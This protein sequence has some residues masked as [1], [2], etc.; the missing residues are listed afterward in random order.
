M[1]P[2]S[3]R[4]AS[5]RLLR[6]AR[7]MAGV[8][9]VSLVIGGAPGVAAPANPF[10]RVVDPAAAAA[11]AVQAQASQAAVSSAAVAQAQASFAQAAALRS[12]MDAA[13][14]AA[15][16]AAAAAQSAVPNGLAAGGLQVA[17]GAAPGTA[18]WQGANA[19]TQSAE[20]NGRTE[21]DVQQTQQQAILNWKSFNVGQQTDLNFDQQGANW[22][23]LNR[24]TDPS[25]NPSQ[26]LGTIKA[27]GTVLIMN[28]NG[29]IFGGASQVNVGALVAGAAEITD[30]QFL[31]NGLYSAQSNGAY[32]PSFSD[33]AGAVVV[34]TGAQIATNAPASVT[35]GGGYVLLMGQQVENQGQ[36]VTPDGQAELAAG[37]AFLIRPGLGTQ[38][39]TTSTTRGNEIAPRIASPGSSTTGGA[40]LVVNTGLIEADTGDVTLAGESV[41]NQGLLLST[42]SVNV[43]GTIHLLSP[44]ND[45]YSSVT[46]APASLA[47]ILPDQSGATAL[48]SQRAAVIAASGADQYDPTYFNDLSQLADLQDE[49]RVEIV[50]GGNVEFQGGSL[51]LANGGQIA[52][53][54]VGRIQ[55]DDGA[56]IDVSGLQDVSL[57][58]AD[59]IIEVNIQGN[60][61]RD[62]PNNRDSG[63]LA[64]DNVYVNAEDLTLV[65][66]GTGGYASDR[67]YTAGGL[68]EV[69]G[70]MGTTGHTIQEWEAVGG[71]ITLSANEVVAQS[72][73]TFN[74]SGG[75]L[76]YQAG[77][78]PQSY[79]IA[80]T[81][82]IYNV[83]NAPADLTYLGVYNGF[84]QDHAHW[85]VSQS[86]G[87]DLVAPSEIYEQ[88]YTVGRDAGSL[89]LSTPTSVF[90]G[91]IVAGVTTGYGQTS[92]RP[93]GV[94]DPYTLPQDV[95]PL[96]GTL[97]IGQ[98]GAYGLAG[99]YDTDVV[100]GD[101]A[102]IASGVGVGT[103]LPS[104]RTGTAWFDAAQINA[105]G[106]GGLNIVTG[107]DVTVAAPL[108]LAP[109]AQVSLV[110]PD[111]SV[112][113]DIV[114]PSGQV[115]L[116]NLMHVQLAQNQ[117][118][119]WSAL[120]DAGG[121]ASVAIQDGATVDLA[122]LWVNA[123]QTPADAAKL[124]FI[125]GGDL[126]VSTT[127]SVTL[128]AGGAID[129]SSGGAILQS[130]ATQGGTGGSV[131]L[132]A[133]DYSRLPE[134]TFWAAEYAGQIS[135]PLIVDGTIRG[136]GFNGGGTL[137]LAAGQ[138]VVIGQD[139]SLSG[140]T[141][142]AG[143]AAG[144][145]VT[146]AQPVT[147]PA[148][149]VMP[150]NY[151][152][153]QN[154]VPLDTP[155]AVALTPASQPLTT[156]AV[157]K[158]PV[159]MTVTSAT[160]A[161]FAG[162]TV[163]AGTQIVS[164]SAIPAGAT[165]PSAVFPQGI[166]LAAPYLMASYTA[167]Q[168][169][170]APVTLPAGFNAPAG[171]VFAQAVAIQPAL[172]LSPALFQS[173]FSHYDISST[174]GVEVAAGTT[175]APTVPVYRFTDASFAAPTGTDPA[176]AGT[177]WTPPVYTE[178]PLADR[179]T[180]RV[181]ASLALNSLHDLTMG[182]GASITVDPGQ[183]VGL[184]A[185]GQTT[186]LG[187]VVAHGGDITVASL[188]G[189]D[190]RYNGGYGDFSLTRS[191]WVGDG[192]VL[193]VS[194]QAYTAVDTWGRI[195]GEAQD[196]GTILLGGTGG[197]GGANPPVASDAF[198]IIRPG[199]VL[200]ASG[201]S[202]TLDLLSP[203]QSS[204][205]PV[206]DATDGGTIGLY[207][208]S[209]IYLDGMVRAAAGGAGAAGGTLDFVEVGH[210]YDEIAPGAANPYAVGVQAYALASAPGGV[211]G[212]V[213]DAAQTL[214]NVTIVQD[215]SGDALG[216]DLAPGQADPG[217]QFGSAVLGVNQIAAGGFDSVT[218]QTRD[219]FVF[220]GDVDLAVG[221]SLTLVGGMITADASTP[222]IA[223]N[224]SAPHVH[225]TGW[226]S[227]NT[228]VSNY[229]SGLNN[230]HGVG[231]QADA[232]SSFTVSAD[233]IDLD[234]AIQFG[235]DAQQGDGVL[236]SLTEIVNVGY[237]SAPQITI[238]APGFHQVTFDSA[239]DVRFGTGSILADN[240]TVQAAQAYP[241]SGA[242][243][244]IS[245]GLY[246]P[247]GAFTQTF[248]P[249][250]TLTFLTNGDA[251]P[252]VPASVF[253]QLSLVA[254]NI[255]QD[256][257]LRAPLGLIVFNEGLS[258]F[259]YLGSNSGFKSAS[260]TF[261]AN[262]VTSVSA[263]GLTMPF[264]GTSDGVTYDGLGTLQPLGAT[265]QT[266]VLLPASGIVVAA[267]S[268][269]ADKGSVL[270][271]SGGGDLTGA[272]F[273]SGRGGSVD[274]LVNPL[275][276][277]DP[278]YAAYSS[279]GDKVYAIVPGYASDYA[280]V[281][282]T[283]GAGDPGIGEQITIGSGVPGLPAGTYTLLPSSY[284]LLPGGFRVE[285]GGSTTTTGAVAAL[286]NG[287]IVTSAALGV[288]NTGVHEALPVQVVLSSGAA[289]RTYSQYDETSYADFAA[290]QATLFGGVRPTLPEDGK[291]LQ[292]SLGLDPTTQSDTFSFEGTALMGGDGDGS[293]AGAL[294]IQG[295]YGSAIDIT[296]ADATP[297]A[298]HVTISSDAIN[299]FDA[300]TVMIGGGTQY[301][302][303]T[304]YGT[305]ERLLF[306][307]QSNTIN[308]LAGADIR[309]GQVFLDGSTI[310]V[311][312]GA[313]IDT[314]GLG[315]GG[316]DSSY[317][318]VYANAENPGATTGPAVLVVANGFFNFLPAVGSGAINIASGA[319]LLTDGSIVIAAPGAANIGD[320][321]LAARY[322][323]VTQQEINI[324]TADSLAAASTAGDLPQGWN[325]T[326]DILDRLLAPPAESG[327]PAL[328]DLTLTAG[329][330]INFIGSV[331]LDASGPDG[332]PVQLVL[333]T[334]AIY[335]LGGAGDV[336][337]ITTDSLVWN[338]V[339][340]GNG[341]QGSPSVPY[342][343]RAPAAITPGGPGTG[344]G[345]L[346]IDAKDITFG[347]D[348]NGRPTDGTTLNRLAVGFSSV[349]LDASDR[350]TASDDGTLTVGQSLNGSGAPVGGALNLTTPL[351]TVQNGAAMS[352]TA[353][354]A[355][356]IAAPAGA[357]AADTAAV[358]NI[359]G[360]LTF[361]GA[362]ISLD[363]AVA[364]PSGQLTLDAAGDV[365]LGDGADIDLS[366]RGLVFND[367]TEYSWGGNLVLS[368][369][370][371]SISQAGGSV[372]DVSAANNDAGSLSA[373]AAN[374]QVTLSGE[375]SGAGGDKYAGG[376][377]S[378][379]A[380]GVGDFDALNAKLNAAG[381]DGALDFDIRS[382]DL[383][384]DQTVKASNVSISVDG[385][386][387]TVT[388][389]IDASGAAPGS[390]RLMA[391]DDLTVAGSAVLDA[392]GDVL[393]ADSYGAPID[394]ENRA[395]V[396]L[397]AGAG[398]LTLQSGATIDVSSPDPNPQGQVI[399]DAPRLGG[400]GASATAGQ[401][402][403]DP[404][405][406]SLTTGADAP[407]N[408]QGDDVAVSAGGP[409]NIK[410]AAD[411]TVNAFATYANAPADPNDANGQV[412]DQAY[413]DLIDQDSQ[414]FISNAYG[415]DVAGGALTA[416]LQGKLAG[417][418]AYGSAFHLRPGVEIDS[419]APGGDLTVVGDLQLAGYRYG[420]NA[421]RD[422]SS[423][424]FGA[425]EPMA[426]V[427]RAGGDLTVTGSISDGFYPTKLE[428][429]PGTPGSYSGVIDNVTTSSY[430][431]Y[432]SSAGGG[433][434][435]GD[436]SAGYADFTTN[437]YLAAD[438][439][440]PD[441]SFYE[442][443]GGLQGADGTY[444]SPGQTIPAGTEL[445]AGYG[446][447]FEDGVTPPP[448]ATG[449][450]AGAPASTIGP[451][452][453]VAAPLAPGSMSASIRLV[454]GADLAAAD[455]RILQTA[456]ALGGSGNVVL[457]DFYSF[458][459]GAG[460]LVAGV[461]VIRTGTG[462]LQ[463]L[464][465]GDVDEVSPYGIYTAGTTIPE[466]GTDANDPYDPA[467][468]VVSATSAGIE[469][470]LGGQYMYYTQDGGDVLVSAQG[471]ITGDETSDATQIGG[472]LWREGGSG[473]DQ[474]TA[475]G[476]NF[477]SYT[478]QVAY[479]GPYLGMS[480][481]DGIGALGGGNVV[482]TAGG[483][484]GVGGQGR[485]IVV[486]VGGSGRVL[487]DG[488]LVQTGGGSLTVT[489]GGNIGSGGNQFVDLR[490]DINVLTTNFGSLTSTN[491]GWDGASDP[492]Q[493][494]SLTPYGALVTEGGS[495]APGD[496]TVT[497][498]A[499]GDL[500][501]GALDDPGRVGLEQDTAGPGGVGL[502]VT[503]FTLWTNQTAINLFGADDVSPLAGEQG[504][505]GDTSSYIIPAILNVTAAG[506][507]IYLRTAQY[508]ASFMMP[509]PDGEVTLLAA[510]SIVAQPN[511]SVAFGPL[512]TSLSTIATPFQPAW[513]LI[514]AGASSTSVL[515]SN[516]WGDPTN[517]LDNVSAMGPYNYAYD[518]LS[519]F[520]GYGGVPFVF[521]ANTV[522]DDS[523]APNPG[524]L[525]RIY[526]LD[527][528]I[529]GLSY[530]QIYQQTTYN[531][532][533][534]VV[535]SF[536]RAAKPVDILAGG[537]IVDLS[538]LILQSDPTD[539]SVIAAS[540]D[541][542]YA[543]AMTPSSAN[544]QNLPGLAIAGPGTLE[545]T[546]GGDIYEG[547]LAS[548]DSIGPLVAG[549]TRPGANI[550]LQA[551]VGPGAPGVGQ[552]DWSG[553]AA[554]Y[555][556]PDNQ[557]NP[558]YPDTDPV[559]AGKAPYT[560]QKELYAWLQQ[561]YGYGGDEAGA[562]AYFETLP[563][564]QQRVFLR[565][566]YYDELN[567]GGLEYNDPTS[568]RFK[569]Y[570][571]GRDA[572]AALFPDQG[573]YKGD[574][575][576]F[577]AAAGTPGTPSYTI[578]SG[579]VHTDFGGNI[580]FLAPGG[581]V[582][583]GTDGLSPGAAAGLI[584]QG[585]GDIDIYSE[586]SVL[587]GLSR[588][589]TT[590]GGN[591]LIWSATGDINAGRGAKT[592]VV[593]TPPKR[594][595]DNYGGVTLAPVTPS[596][597]AGIATLAPIPQVP[598]G[599]I[600]LV[601]PLGTVDAGEAGI[602][603]SGNLNIAALQVLN[604][605]NIQVQGTA[606][607]VPTAA[608]VNIGALTSA[609][610]AGAA[611]TQIAQQMVNRQ[612]PPPP[613]A[614]TILTV[615]F[616]GFGDD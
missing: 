465:G 461:S 396:E 204:G 251:P 138:S 76:Q 57:P 88:G 162:D 379:E 392:H 339:R 555:L 321:D 403:V 303:D 581:G 569:S 338:G 494:S 224:L 327:L 66:A 125:D 60:E 459:S 594:V 419:A 194:G 501:M 411:V 164:M 207:S 118:V 149:S 574:I 357:A 340:T 55:V 302:D 489:A 401:T 105:E 114:A 181:G 549:D 385:G 16:A 373:T 147:I 296:G 496:G 293:F 387:L 261:G 151:L 326:Q 332:A 226:N 612:P 490:G 599:D 182:A 417:L 294:V 444:Y 91:N 218:L 21:V 133:D 315:A 13:Q 367:V 254:P 62:D 318:Y 111:I 248:N 79:V 341:G 364:M 191:I 15:R 450:V 233:L 399:L 115:T 199:A 437:L 34:Q 4:P 289:V 102:P 336:A 552:V 596:T 178:N 370:D 58:M 536:Y 499:R 239:G 197:A 460:K 127:G 595:Y 73:S 23:V 541:I 246:L 190:G 184:Y 97:A 537:D 200:D 474:P 122:G 554:L 359:G 271:L 27:P 285:I 355:I 605:A 458:D 525:S 393:Q 440:I 74:I 227:N 567:A 20:A 607:G 309:A 477:G 228:I 159:G 476:I 37:D 262:S 146:L 148:G 70:Y 64:S 17:D 509:S 47:A 513:E 413:L 511:Y 12:Q 24:I 598:P 232:D 452:P 304:A 300:P 69:S 245:V 485:G 137:T 433:I 176:Q 109:G 280:P 389:L 308:V 432:Y 287:S 71:S 22:V 457:K 45:P 214:R 236:G 56:V 153:T 481:F 41:L 61:L 462:D 292:I 530:G 211:I 52:A 140:G 222:D 11:A 260:I 547:S 229:Y 77:Y 524:V 521:G 354:G 256:G 240:L 500:A 508:G 277:S 613:V 538:G 2:R 591:I 366:G 470:G 471:D 94:S 491:F 249:D 352:V 559:N 592:T 347:A 281:I 172:S 252:P 325:L 50:T 230:D 545:V 378:V 334:P 177:L 323:T 576:L 100:F 543:G 616:L 394:S 597:G 566:V 539:V 343:S 267:D 299:A 430:F 372:I 198:V 493:L 32:A 463:I 39:N 112:D 101:V 588:I 488:S 150:V 123:L 175:V 316:V 445:N 185:N 484:I 241:L 486:A 345:A 544:G 306:T 532:G 382:G 449:Y 136:Y 145:S 424:G 358:D 333:N 255:D 615:Q 158:V 420:P 497:V 479:G 593:Y 313:T 548:I 312:D 587:L 43:R 210:T 556:N 468:G 168:V 1:S 201:T 560:Y 590:F 141:L 237:V 570:L 507:N 374:G 192:A 324:G 426:L 160:Q 126:T 188:Q 171:T 376:R 381:F 14:A 6:R 446:I 157:W 390:I 443:A 96:A 180:Q 18:L 89:V 92:S 98:Y 95:A 480:T 104:E 196:G 3:L 279:A 193:D 108:A 154:A 606:T 80:T 455:N 195:Y 585:D 456:A 553:F 518:S 283:N 40:G 268:V 398:T 82:Q 223:V 135:N 116:T 362:S 353:G 322:L 571:R 19:P 272:G 377:F 611:V 121:S 498:R 152:A 531:G 155:L 534:A 265:N 348:P 579:Y 451:P 295:V 383:V 397:G 163:P 225:L 428:T 259:N 221:R 495:F 65:P 561:T 86:Y 35:Q 314:H 189:A 469:A 572:I 46:L 213:P 418:L 584:T 179:L 290:T 264:G 416:N 282:A 243:M 49:S 166:A 335:G 337:S 266:S 550:V 132:S 363:T 351:I 512:S 529:I 409:L 238:D 551:G 5:P 405:D 577:S 604:A 361:N 235:V 540:G 436:G 269:V 284:A 173:G 535:S 25:A 142:P 517:V 258:G 546:A 143:V 503:W 360:S 30:S 59:N 93:S 186:L 174:S 113:A 217:L 404:V 583:V 129:V 331:A 429:I 301:W 276:D 67:Y 119:Q 319:T 406:G 514:S 165:V 586:D 603:V 407:A 90:E 578:T 375:L 297:V 330:S 466:T 369:A 215:N 134:T 601:A 278:A 216:A 431:S 356:T 408:A 350:I 183:S 565:Q 368:S 310:N 317:G 391:G 520:S 26:I 502:G 422:S 170:T 33:A 244:S 582:Q 516:Y 219:L 527:G 120:T 614:P 85:G 522:T 231:V 220:K 110:A 329:G 139:A 384:V 482:V 475:W 161:Y 144:T 44:T 421:N 54:A 156:A 510:G 169:L 483:N 305:G 28:A 307:G 106:L 72:G 209:G 472:W 580:Q 270:D 506:G 29:I 447:Y 442:T 564:P 99:A 434:P 371:G 602:R 542:I 78:L 464:A 83:N 53:S 38:A 128:A 505:F 528:D 349:S 608:A 504:T 563:A 288:A 435:Y 467:R 441:D 320:V 8:S 131:T 454:G 346:E 412:I 342:G 526:A 414:A 81:G 519:G 523:A 610:N 533:K 253:G 87:S 568:K 42:T 557:A 36:I 365:G 402:Y 84:T 275:V 51:V 600:N 448:L 117:N 478:A 423:A 473:L 575:V 380:Q 68:L 492:R 487:A 208:A 286:A 400:T 515:A 10:A 130:G 558:A 573:A 48:D 257:V 31:N 203:G 234:G 242:S 167:G 439:T 344:L 410:G 263:A 438:W 427:I 274:V 107:G 75:S 328:Q 562:Y 247:P 609:S 395:T 212:I 388:G 202:A 291:V 187:E 63:A 386:S 205:E 9:A 124:A 206:L 250:A 425:G 298:G 311:A 589:M 103:A 273:I 7:L 453:P 415:G